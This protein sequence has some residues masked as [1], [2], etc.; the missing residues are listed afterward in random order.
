M[1]GILTVRFHFCSLASQY[2]TQVVYSPGPSALVR[3]TFTQLSLAD[4]EAMTRRALRGLGGSLRLR[5]ERSLSRF[6]KGGIWLE[7]I[8][9]DWPRFVCRSY[10][11]MR[12]N[13]DADSKQNQ[14]VE[15]S[16]RKS[17]P[18]KTAKGG[19]ASGRI[20]ARGGPVRPPPASR[21]SRKARRSAKPLPAPT[22]YS[23]PGP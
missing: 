8:A 6:S 1:L 14:T 12:K 5:S 7:E 10:C 15:V 18:L 9:S 17:Y 13:F 3:P 2:L 4:I 21:V 22:R 16:I 11:C 20:G 23:P 19:A